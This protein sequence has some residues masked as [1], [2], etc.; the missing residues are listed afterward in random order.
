MEQQ[1]V[2]QATVQERA[3]A[4]PLPSHLGITPQPWIKPTFTCI[5]LNSALA[6]TVDFDMTDGATSYIS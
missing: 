1:V 6:G 5:P 4:R 2:K 3:P